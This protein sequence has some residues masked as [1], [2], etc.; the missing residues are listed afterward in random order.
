MKE[1]SRI[2]DAEWEIMNL[3]WNKTPITAN[4]IVSKLSKEKNWSPK[5]IGTFL[6]RLVKKGALGFEQE[7]KRYLYFPKMNRASCIKSEA[8]SFL[9]RVFCGEAAS[10][11]THFVKEVKLSPSEIAELEQIL[12]KKGNA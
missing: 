3:V 11:L 9:E 6:T 12:A 2:S 8:K 7:G 10:F 5:T 1:L 4:E